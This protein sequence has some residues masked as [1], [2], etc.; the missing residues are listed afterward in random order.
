[1][2]YRGQIPKKFTFHYLWSQLVFQSHLCWDKLLLK[3]QK[4]SLHSLCER[5]SG[6]ATAV[7]ESG[8]DWCQS[9]EAWIYDACSFLLSTKN[10]KISSAHY[11]MWIVIA[12]FFFIINT[13][14]QSSSTCCTK[15]G[16]PL[17]LSSLPCLGRPD[18]YQTHMVF[19]SHCIV[20]CVSLTYL[21]YSC[22][23]NL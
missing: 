21:Q 22:S 23:N 18:Q 1:M 3:T 17:F 13:C 7:S 5:R 20:I 11:T 14:Q 16:A 15:V 8:L 6:P 2:V 4:D 19:P 9:S 10:E 12:D